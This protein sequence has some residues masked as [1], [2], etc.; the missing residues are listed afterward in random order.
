MFLI[1]SSLLLCLIGFFLLVNKNFPRHPYSLIGITCLLESLYFSPFLIM[2]CNYDLDSG[3]L[4]EQ[5]HFRTGIKIISDYK[6][7]EIQ[8]YVFAV[9]KITGIIGT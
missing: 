1:L 9:L 7:G 2:K 4:K 3:Q 8:L 5:F 6:L